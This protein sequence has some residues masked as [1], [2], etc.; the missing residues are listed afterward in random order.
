MA[1]GHVDLRE[2][3][4]DL[5]A[6]PLGGPDDR[7]LA[8]EWMPAADAV[9]LKLVPRSHR[10]DQHLITRS[11]IGREV[12]GNEERP[13]RGAA[14]HEDAWDAGKVVHGASIVIAAKQRDAA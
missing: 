14:A 4:V 2:Q 9:D 11:R 12:R 6:V 3:V 1:L 7:N 8:G 5:G 13:A 10:G